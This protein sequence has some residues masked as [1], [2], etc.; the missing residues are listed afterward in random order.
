MGNN[1][2]F[3]GP[4]NSARTSESADGNALPE[5]DL[6]S[7]IVAGRL[8]LVT[9]LLALSRGLTFEHIQ[10]AARL[11]TVDVIDVLLAADASSI[12]QDRARRVV[13][14]TALEAGSLQVASRLLTLETPLDAE[15]IYW[16]ISKVVSSSP[17]GASIVIQTHQSADV[18]EDFV[19]SIAVAADNVAL[20]AEF[21]PRNCNPADWQAALT[22]VALSAG[23]PG[24]QAKNCSKHI[25][26]MI[27]QQ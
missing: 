2:T 27:Q 8:D 12:E 9:S 24:S 19:I 13:I 18:T 10:A 25:L 17:E 6:L 14:T 15:K 3:S 22:A 16:C 20:L 23:T 7:A 11:P 4:G 26:D 5:A 1:E 21:L